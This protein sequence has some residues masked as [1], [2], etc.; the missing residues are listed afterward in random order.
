MPIHSWKFQS[1]VWDTI[2]LKSIKKIYGNYL[3]ADS[4][5]NTVSEIRAL[6]DSQV[7]LT[8]KA[9]H[10]NQLSI[11]F[12]KIQLPE[13]FLRAILVVGFKNLLFF[14]FWVFLTAL[15]VIQHIVGLEIQ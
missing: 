9:K 12:F 7:I 11:F 13:I 14:V 3:G 10:Q 8:I 1:E 6:R 2:E 5:T 15:K 4:I